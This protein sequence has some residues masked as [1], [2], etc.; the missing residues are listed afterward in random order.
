MGIL[1]CLLIFLKRA[2]ENKT[3]HIK[4]WGKNNSSGRIN[5]DQIKKQQYIFA[6]LINRSKTCRPKDIWMPNLTLIFK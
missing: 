2:L 6:W 4:V 3:Y 5:H 1:F